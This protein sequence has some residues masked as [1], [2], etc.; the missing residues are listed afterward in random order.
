M[1]ARAQDDKARAR[2]VLAFFEWALTQGR[3]KA[4]AIQY[5]TVPKEHVAAIAEIWR[6]QIRVEGQP[7]W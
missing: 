5:V 7:I 2:R 1:L 4:Q 6:E 3:T